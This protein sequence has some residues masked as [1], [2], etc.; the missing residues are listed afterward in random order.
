M[1][2]RLLR[3]LPGADE[4]LRRPG[5]HPVPAAPLRV[6]RDRVLPTRPPGPANRST[7]R[8]RPDLHRRRPGP[9][10]AD[11]RRRHARDQARGAGRGG[12]RR[13]RAC[14]PSAA[15]TSSSA[16]ATSWATSGSPG[17]GLADLETV[18]EPGPRL[19]GNVEIEVD[20][21]EGPRTLAGFENHGG[22]TY[23]GDGAKPL[24]RVIQGLREQRQ[25]RLRG[26][27]PRAT[28]S[29]PTS[30]ARCCRRTPGWPTA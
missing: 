24:G 3:A 4:H 17:L 18:R 11:R 8:P 14:S 7:R 21:G 10:P 19:I 20:L 9:R 13:R 23:L 5:Q 2:L 15:A 16:T 12:R 26:R 30:T 29:G 28:C 27:A 25:R 6:A 1:E 22:R